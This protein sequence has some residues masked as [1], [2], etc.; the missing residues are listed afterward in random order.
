MDQSVYEYVMCLCVC[1]C[2]FQRYCRISCIRFIPLCNTWLCLFNHTLTMS[3]V[4][5]L[6][7]FLIWEMLI[8]SRCHLDFCF[9][10][11]ELLWHLLNLF[12]LFHWS[13]ADAQNICYR[14][15]TQWFPIFKDYTPLMSIVKYLLN[16]LCCAIY[17]RGSFFT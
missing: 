1:I 8:Y 12:P 10:N 9:P 6:K 13:T 7:V 11:Y 4:Q 3:F 16:L 15:T 17:H 5:L 14:Y 2:D